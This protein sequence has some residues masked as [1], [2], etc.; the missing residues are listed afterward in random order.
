MNPG[1]WNEEKVTQAFKGERTDYALI[2]QSGIIT[3]L[4]VTNPD[5]PLS[6]KQE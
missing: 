5:V 1:Q 2:L 4:C 6:L 3:D